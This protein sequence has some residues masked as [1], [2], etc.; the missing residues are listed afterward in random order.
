MKEMRFF[1]LCVSFVYFWFLQDVVAHDYTQWG[2]PEGAKF[3]IGKGWISEIAC[4]PD[5]DWIAVASSIGVWLYDAH[6]GA[7]ISLITGHRAVVR[8]VTFSPDGQTL[9]SGSL[10]E[11]VCLWDARTGEHKQTF[12]GHR[13]AVTSV[14]FSPDG[15]T[16]VSS[17][18][19]EDKTIRLWDVRTGRQLQALP[20]HT[21]R[22]ST[23]H[24]PLMDS[25]SLAEV[26]ITLVS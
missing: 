17:S 24:F 6:S 1:K 5:G 11:T 25:R 15:Q 16:V 13:D 19:D 2:L 14:A 9:A 4:S 22:V 12:I 26:M 20:G 18:G 7:E 8:C 21:G 3:R 10:D 23:L